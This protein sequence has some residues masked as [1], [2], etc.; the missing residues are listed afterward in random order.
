MAV[1]CIWIFPH[2]SIAFVIRHRAAWWCEN[3]DRKA[4]EFSFQTNT[5]RC[6]EFFWWMMIE[7]YFLFIKTCRGYKYLSHYTIAT[8]PIF[9][10]FNNF[11]IVL[12]SFLIIS[13][14][15]WIIRNWQLKSLV[16]WIGREPCNFDVIALLGFLLFYLNAVDYCV[17]KERLCKNFCV[18]VCNLSR[19]ISQWLQES[20]LC[21]TWWSCSK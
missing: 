12:N 18:K 3:R 8:F 17:S 16:S 5:C 6:L 21:N 1:F 15:C 11:Y 4:I 2:L 14:N 20:S 10:K 7:F 19:F 13:N 9:S